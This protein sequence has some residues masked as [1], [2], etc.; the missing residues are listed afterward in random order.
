M[1]DVRRVVNDVVQEAG[2]SAGPQR[3]FP[4]GRIRRTRPAGC[5]AGSLGRGFRGTARLAAGD[6]AGPEIDLTRLSIAALI[7]AFATALE[8]ALARQ[9]DGRAAELGRWGGWLVMAA[10]LAELRSRLLLPADSPEARAAAEEAEALRRRLVSRAQMRAAADWLERRPQLGRDVFGRGSRPTPRRRRP[11]GDITELLRACLVALHVPEQADAYPP[12]PAPLWQASDAIARIRQLLDVLQDGSPLTAFLPVVDGVEPARALRHR[13]AISST[14][15]AGLELARTGTIAL[16][17]DTPWTSI[18]VKH[19]AAA[20]SGDLRNW[21]R[22]ASGVAAGGR[23]L[24]AHLRPLLQGSRRPTRRNSRIR[25]SP[26]CPDHRAHAA[27][28]EQPAPRTRAPTQRWNWAVC[29]S[30]SQTRLSSICRGW[31]PLVCQGSEAICQA[32]KS[33]LNVRGRSGLAISCGSMV[34]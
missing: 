26:E 24:P 13:V 15:V 21:T 18:R 2:G 30:K 33:I 32:E 6:G 10:T 7:D 16:D 1:S 5:G 8:A 27:T 11:G 9:T 25:R 31:A 19:G 14:L 4:P 20:A 23:C 34:G 12:W 17:Q 3:R 29:W 22:C 28:F